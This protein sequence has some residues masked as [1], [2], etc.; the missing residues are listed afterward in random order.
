MGCQG[1]KD[2]QIYLKGI[3]TK[4]SRI[5]VVEAV[6]ASFESFKH[7][8]FNGQSEFFSCL[9]SFLKV[10]GML[11]HVPFKIELPI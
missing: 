8:G 4:N 2:A 7:L 11:Q 6:K 10:L 3:V 1:E 5:G 9:I